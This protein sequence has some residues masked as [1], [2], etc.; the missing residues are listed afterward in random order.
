MPGEK[1]SRLGHVCVWAIYTA[2]GQAPFLGPLSAVAEGE[3]CPL[4]GRG[5]P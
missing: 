2:R 5:A 4:G 3:G 1:V